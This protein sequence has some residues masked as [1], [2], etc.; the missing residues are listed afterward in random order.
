MKER[1]KEVLKALKSFEEE[2]E[3]L[4]RRDPLGEDKEERVP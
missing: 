4:I 2:F 1:S 3:R